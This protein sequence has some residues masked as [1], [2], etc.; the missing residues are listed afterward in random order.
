MGQITKNVRSRDQF[1]KYETKTRSLRD[2]DRDR[3]QKAETETET[4]T[5]LE[6][7]ITG[8][9]TFRHHF[10]KFRKKI[11]FASHTAKT[12]CGFWL[13]T[14][15]KTLHITALSLVYFTTE[16]C[17]LVSCRSVHTCLHDILD[18]VIRCLHPTPTD[19]LP[20][21]LGIQ[22]AELLRLGVTLL[23]PD[24]GILDSEHLWH[25]HL[26]R[27]L[28]AR[29]ERLK[30]RRPFV[31]VAPKLLDNESELDILVGQRTDVTCN[32]VYLN[33]PSKLHNF[34]PRFGTRFLGLGLRR[35]T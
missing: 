19:N 16:Y 35:L 1:K 27:P 24:R 8:T 4:K 21:L 9:L 7:F 3:Q 2:Q 23:L 33:S 15:A 22:P 25:D 34:I 18:I 31:P 20:I 28:D 29:Q 5:G 14:G 26:V 32:I 11:I 12:T 30:S 17:A 13:G 6:T 10:E